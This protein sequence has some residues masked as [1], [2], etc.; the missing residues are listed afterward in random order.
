MQAPPRGDARGD[1]G[2]TVRTLERGRACRQ[3]VAGG[4]IGRTVER[5]VRP[6]ERAGRNLCRCG[7]QTP[8][9]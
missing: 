4:A 9:Q 1:L 8:Q 3:L 6:R 7:S 5:L 2:V